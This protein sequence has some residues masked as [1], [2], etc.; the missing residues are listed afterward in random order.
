MFKKF[1]AFAFSLIALVLA[2]SLSTLS[3]PAA[4]KGDPITL[5]YLSLIHI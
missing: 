5:G 4:P 3:S 2:I 1:K